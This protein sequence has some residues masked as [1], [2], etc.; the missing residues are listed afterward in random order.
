MQA[1]AQYELE[2]CV[3][4]VKSIADIMRKLIDP[5]EISPNVNVGFETAPK[6]AV[7]FQDVLEGVSRYYSVSVNDMLGES[8]V[9][10][11]VTPRQ[12]AMYI[13]KKH[14]RM[15]FVRLGESFS[16]RD[17]TTVMH[18]VGKIETKIQD[19]AQLM[20][21]VRTIEREVGLAA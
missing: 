6:Q 15:S 5:T 4:T 14:L 17:H 3:P 1:V 8:R 13:G 18:A 20:R 21:E 2:H 11:I 9:R 10:E 16:N 7:S 12:I 19:D